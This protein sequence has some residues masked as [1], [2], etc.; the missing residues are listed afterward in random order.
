MIRS[1]IYSPGFARGATVAAGIA[2]LIF[3]VDDAHS[4]VLGWIAN[5]H[6]ILSTL[7]GVIARIT[8]DRARRDGWKPGAFLTSLALLGAM[9]SGES[10]LGALAYLF[11]YALFLDRAPLRSR[12]AALLPHVGAA[13]VWFAAYKLGRRWTIRRSVWVVWEKTRFVPFVVPKV[14]ETSDLVVVSY[15]TA[16]GG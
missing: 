15:Q 1:H 5:R 3:A 14:G 9:F 4:M 8:H 6:A 7:F 11:A 10:G 16:V 2:A 12:V 13:L